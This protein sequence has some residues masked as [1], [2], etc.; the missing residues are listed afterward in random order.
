MNDLHKCTDF[1]DKLFE[2]SENLPTLP[3]IAAKLLQAFQKENPDIDEI[4]KIL[5]T[6]PPLSAKVL[7]IVNSSFYSLPSKITSVNHAI[8]LLGIN[9]VKNL[10]LS[11]SLVNKFNSKASKTLDH[12]LFWKDSL[13]GAIAVKLIGEKIIKSFSD[14][15]DIFFLGLLQNIGLFTLSCCM[16]KQYDLV[17]AQFHK[18]GSQV[19]EVESQSLGYNHMEIGEYLIKSW[20]LP[21][22]FYT[23]IG[24]HHYPQRLTSARDDIHTLTKV[25]HLSS[26][27]IELFNHSSDVG[28]QMAT[29]EQRVKDYGFDETIDIHEVGKTINQQA[30]DILPIFEIEFKDEN[31]YAQLL[32]TAKAEI[33]NL[34]AELIN[35][36][37]DQRQEINLLRQ[38]V[39]C[40]S[41]T[42]LNNHQRF[43]ELLQQE[44]SRSHRYNH[45]LSVIFADIDH[46]KSVNDTYGHL[47]GDRVIKI[48]AGCLLKELRE[49]DHLARYGGEEFAAIL[50]ETDKDDAWMAAER[51]RKAIDSLRIA[52]GDSLIHVTMSF[53]IALLKPG[54]EISLDELISKADSVLYNAKNQGRNQCSFFEYKN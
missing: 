1:F 40:D 54:E 43:R 25:L 8:K 30:S 20:G 42:N 45:P 53:G 23:P 3:G 21:D 29:I 39:G 19:H 7:K 46:F 48:V 32:E 41:M 52:H 44:I 14:S 5:S 9:C 6:D 49:S 13:I 18:N 4:G 35:N 31:E 26:L 38:Q 51:L 22:T 36:L 27:Y 37:L 24:Y 12:A 10:A 2:T 16:P 11:F 50:P 47:A 28:L 17:M 34:S 15:D 33:A